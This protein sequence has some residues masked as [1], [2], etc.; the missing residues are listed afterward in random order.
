ML[1]GTWGFIALIIGI[2]IIPKVT[3]RTQNDWRS[4]KDTIG[5]VIFS[6]D[7]IFVSTIPETVK[8][9]DVLKLSLTGD[10]YKGCSLGSRD[11]V[12]NGLYSFR[13]EMKSS[14][15]IEFKF[16][17]FTELKFTLLTSFIE[18]LYSSYKIDINEKI[19]SENQTGLLLRH[20]RSYDDIQ[21]I[22]QRLGLTEEN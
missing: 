13:I 3:R 14:K 10:Y 12:H 15:N 17:V 8:L 21:N 20:N 16:V 7:A 5:D 2:I 6:E 11:I 4:Q 9:H 1:S 22:K 19:G 18:H